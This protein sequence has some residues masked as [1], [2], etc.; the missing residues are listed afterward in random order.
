MQSHKTEI[1]LEIL[2]FNIQVLF[3]KLIYFPKIYFPQTFSWPFIKD[4]Y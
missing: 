1:L 4:V 3:K 2:S